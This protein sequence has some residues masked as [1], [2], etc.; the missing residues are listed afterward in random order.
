MSDSANQLDITG[1][2]VFFLYPSAAVQNQIITELTQQEFEVYV[3]KEHNNFAHALKKYTDSILFINIDDGMPEQEWAVWIEKVMA[4]YPNIKIGIFSSSSDEALH[5][6]YVDDL[7][8]QCG[9][10]VSKFDIAKNTGK[11]LEMLN[12]L[13]VKGRRKYVR[14]ETKHETTATINM[15][16][17]GGFVNG[18]IKDISVVGISCVFDKED[19]EIAKNA[20]LKDIQIRL[21]TMLV[22]V[23][24]ILFGCRVDSDNKIH[25]L[26]FTQRIDPDVRVKIRKYIQQSLQ[27]QM[28]HEINQ[29]GQKS[30]GIH[31]ADASDSG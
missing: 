15:P 13:N 5:N 27:H 20:L 23:E 21:Q 26:I 24:A 25:V 8:V 11:I 31:N 17:N 7:H 19:V 10:M 22:K 3:V 2:K 29:I 16:H 6:K 28:D 12:V 1:K 4:A 14:A 18:V 9:F 30:A